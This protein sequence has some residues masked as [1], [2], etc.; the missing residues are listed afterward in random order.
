M[1][2]L[3]LSW[4]K[5]LLGCW[6]S[7]ECCVDSGHMFSMF[8]NT[9]PLCMMCSADFEFYSMYIKSL[10]S[11][12]NLVLKFHWF[13]VFR[14]CCRMHMLVRILLYCHICWIFTFCCLL[15]CLVYNWLLSTICVL[16][17]K[18]SQL[19]S[20]T[21]LFCGFFFSFSLLIKGNRALCRK[22]N[23]RYYFI[24]GI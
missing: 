15:N 21:D 6:S 9:C 3:S 12:L 19:I 24:W 22:P 14:I 16:D 18:L 17:L 4:F 7:C 10:L 23:F 2:I 5:F 11:S 20:W 8:L 13:F 1:L